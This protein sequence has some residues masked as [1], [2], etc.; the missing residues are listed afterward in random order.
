MKNIIKCIYYLNQIRGRKLR[1]ILIYATNR[2]NSKCLHCNIWKQKPKLDLDLEIFEDM[3]TA[4]CTN[5][6]LYKTRFGLEG[7]EFILHP[8]YKEILQLFNDMEKEYFLLS[9]G[10]LPKKLIETVREFGIKELIISLDGNKRVHAKVRGIDIFNNIIYII[11]QL[12]KET[13]IS[14]TYTA[15]PYN[16]A[17][18]Y[19]FVKEFCKK[20][21]LNMYFSIFADYKLFNVTHDVEATKKSNL[22]SNY[23]IDNRYAELY[24]Q[25][26][27]NKLNL[28]CISPLFRITVNPNGDI[29]FCCGKKII[30][31]NLY[32]SKLDDI[33]YSM[34][35]KK[36]QKMF[37][38]KCNDCW[39]SCHRAA[40]IFYMDYFNS[41]LPGFISRKIIEY[42]A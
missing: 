18:D 7:G 37:I 27:N 36:I 40:D 29:P 30:L 5:S 41:N 24:N 14:L 35:T 22:I 15:T 25:W 8:K 34:K 17:K 28:P 38:N 42:Y 13:N 31:G 33:W 19:I 20:N 9:N 11:D 1:D 4:K 2:C 16:S 3:L 12:K 26:R 39:I 6:K 21:R 23:P 32:E 10:S